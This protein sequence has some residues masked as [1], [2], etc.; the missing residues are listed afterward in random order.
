MTLPRAWRQWAKARSRE[1]V[2]AGVPRVLAR[3][4]AADE[5]EARADIARLV[6]TT[7]AMEALVSVVHGTVKG[8]NLHVRFGLDLDHALIERGPPQ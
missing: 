4:L 6:G 7:A 3:K 1:M 2:A 5:A 8:G